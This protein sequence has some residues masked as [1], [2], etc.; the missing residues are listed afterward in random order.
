[1]HRPVFYSR[2][3]VSETRFCLRLKVEPTQLGAI[4]TASLRLSLF[5]GFS[6]VGIS[7]KTTTGEDSKLRRLYVC[8]VLEMELKK[9]RDGFPLL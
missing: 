2:H 3:D 8:S 6:I 7:H 5:I 1:M 4:G 9:N